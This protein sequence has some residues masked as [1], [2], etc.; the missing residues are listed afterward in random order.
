MSAAPIS[1]RA[2]LAAVEAA[3]DESEQALTMHEAMR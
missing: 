3:F 2:T 1:N